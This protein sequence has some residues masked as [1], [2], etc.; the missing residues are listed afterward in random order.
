[1]PRIQLWPLIAASSLILSAHVPSAQTAEA[2]VVSLEEIIITALPIR[3]T[4]L[5]T[6]QLILVVEGD[7]LLRSRTAS[8]G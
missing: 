6:A 7:T 8:L 3:R 2:E 5:E 1:M 4:A